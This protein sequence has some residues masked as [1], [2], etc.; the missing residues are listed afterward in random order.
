[1]LIRDWMSRDV[2]SA[3]PEMSMMRAAKLMKEH[4]FDR[5]P[6]VDKDNKLVGIISDR[7]IKEASPS[8]ATTLD[9]HELYYLLSEIK[10]NDIM[11]RDV[12][13]A[14]PDDTVENAALVMLERDFSGMPVVD[15]DG[16][17]TGIITDKDIFKVLLSIT[18]ARHGGVQF[19]FLLPN[20]PG[21]LKPIVDTL[22]EH[23]A[24]I[25]SILTFE[26]RD[27]GMRQVFIRIR[28]MDR[29]DE[30]TLIEQLKSRYRVTYWSRANVHTVS[31]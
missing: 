26:D 28:P 12:V 4:S 13:A 29:S 3:T 17:L 23:K 15:D 25:T 14:K 5:L 20:S 1:M 9:V 24:R 30:N 8:K 19:G 16:R 31:F 11:T 7:D 21:T 6:I 22:R 10:V 18:G 27:D 2:I